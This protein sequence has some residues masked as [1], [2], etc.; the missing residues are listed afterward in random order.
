[1]Q[2][3]AYQELMRQIH[4]DIYVGLKNRAP[5]SECKKALQELANEISES[6]DW[7]SWEPKRKS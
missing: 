2:L 1:M 5:A 3:P 6:V 4:V 7:A